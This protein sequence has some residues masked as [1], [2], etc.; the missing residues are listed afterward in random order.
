MALLRPQPGAF[1][2]DQVS[3]LISWD[4]GSPSLISCWRWAYPVVT[5]YNPWPETQLGVSYLILSWLGIFICWVHYLSADVIS[6]QLCDIESKWMRNCSVVIAVLVLSV[7]LIDTQIYHVFKFHINPTVWELLLKEAQSK[8]ELNWNFLFIV[9]PVLFPV[10]T[11][12]FQLRMEDAVTPPEKPG[13][14]RLALYWS[15][16]FVVAYHLH[17]CRCQAL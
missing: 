6:T 9:I 17:G 11:G 13:V 14:Q 8:A 2:R 16:V 7:L 15:V 1:Y 5:F 3:R 4:I 12:D 10:R